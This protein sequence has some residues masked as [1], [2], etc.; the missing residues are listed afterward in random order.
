[1]EPETVL[2]MMQA[3]L[4]HDYARAKELEKQMAELSS[5]YNKYMD[6]REQLARHTS[7]V[8]R[9]RGIMAD[10]EQAPP[11]LHDEEWE[12]WQEEQ[13]LRNELELWEVAEQYLQCVP[14]AKVRDILNF[15]EKIDLHSSRQAVEAAIKS[16][17][18][19]FAVRKRKGENIVSLKK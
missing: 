3:R 1:M 7:S 10:Q 4:R 12:T 6:L 18:K 9:L 13:N 19:L 2:G 16:R 15:F 5:A 11:R 14:E 17:P 8:E